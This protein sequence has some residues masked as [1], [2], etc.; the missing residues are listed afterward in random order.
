[1]NPDPEN[2]KNMH[3]QLIQAYSN[4]PDRHGVSERSIVP[5]LIPRPESI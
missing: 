3:M 4:Y 2:V 5:F 1:M